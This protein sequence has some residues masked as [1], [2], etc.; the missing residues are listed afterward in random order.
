[1]KFHEREFFVARIMSGRL[2]YEKNGL[3]LF[4]NPSTVEQN[5]EAQEVFKNTYE[6]ALSEG[7]MTE[8]ECLLM[9]VEQGLWNDEDQESMDG[10]E[11]D[12]E[13]L[14]I[15]I[16]E[17]FFNE[18]TRDAARDLLKKASK[19]L[20]ELHERRHF[21][22]F[23]NCQGVATYARFY[24]IIE[25]TTKHADGSECNWEEISS[26]DILMHYQ[27]S[28]ISESQYRELA[29][30][31][32]WRTIWSTGKANGRLFD[33]SGIELTLEQRT[34]M[35]WSG[36][37]DSVGESHE[38]PPDKVIE[39]DDALDG[40]L[41]VQKRDRERDKAKSQAESK[42]SEKT[43]NA[44]EVYLF[45]D[46]EAVAA[47]DTPESKFTRAQRMKQLE[48]SGGKGVRHDKFEDMVQQRI[49][50]QNQTI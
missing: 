21:Y 33:K 3:T 49:I 38:S 14:K 28:I 7:I 9:L 50:Q 36:L 26:Q 47:L 4:I 8:E 30:T 19:K 11:K 1:M 6:K 27:A 17:A 34:L 46:R 23:V 15:E 43:M 13:Q 2:K 24:W 29:R 20:S 35:A 31:E 22:D 37:Y 44:D 16:Y 48:E 25:N 12:I 45:G 41:L 32:P 39:D 40:W 42:M 5:Y 18:F 10:L